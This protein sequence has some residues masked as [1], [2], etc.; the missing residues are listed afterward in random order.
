VTL[1]LS[2]VSRRLPGSNGVS[3]KAEESPLLDAVTRKRLL[4]TLQAGDN[5]VFGAVIC[6][7]W[8]LTATVIICGFISF[9][10]VVNKSIHQQKPRL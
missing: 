3:A 5:L 4:K 9:L 2:L 7:A 1:T 8:R 6:K 10:T